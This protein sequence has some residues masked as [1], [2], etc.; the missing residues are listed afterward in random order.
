VHYPSDAQLQIVTLP[1]PIV[2]PTSDQ[3]PVL[4]YLA[5]RLKRN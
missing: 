1:T 2:L 3:N 4:I 5:T